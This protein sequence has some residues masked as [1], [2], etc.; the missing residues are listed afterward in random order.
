MMAACTTAPIASGDPRVSVT[1]D[2][3]VF[4]E[5][6]IVV[7]GSPLRVSVRL[8]NTSGIDRPV[9]ETTDWRNAAGQPIRSLMSAPQR[10]TVPRHGDAAISKIAPNADAVQ[11]R[12]R[13]EPDFT[14]I[15]P[16]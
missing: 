6:L 10:L 7:E 8:V 3:R 2:A 15:D 16:S 4:A 13:V 9:I 5:D 14:A 11:F 1:P 12:I